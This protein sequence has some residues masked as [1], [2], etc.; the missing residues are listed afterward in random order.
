MIGQFMKNFLG[1]KKD[2]TNQDK[3]FLAKCW[4]KQ[5]NYIYFFKE[6]RPILSINCLFKYFNSPANTIL[7]PAN[8][9]FVFIGISI[10]K[11]LSLTSSS[12]EQTMQIWTNFVLSTGL[13]CM[14]LRA[15]SYKNFLSHDT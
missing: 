11:A 13:D 12:T 14:T 9:T 5:I 3:K 6:S 8:F 1:E 15:A 4:H 7:V 2:N 10:L